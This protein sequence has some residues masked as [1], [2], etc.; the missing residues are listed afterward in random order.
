MIQKC[1]VVEFCIK[2]YEVFYVEPDLKRNLSKFLCYLKV[3][4][5]TLSNW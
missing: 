4:C 5:G 2:G 1:F 3:P